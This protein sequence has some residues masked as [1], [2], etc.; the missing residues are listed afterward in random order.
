[1][2]L[3]APLFSMWHK[4]LFYFVC[5]AD[6]L[7]AEL[8]QVMAPLLGRWRKASRGLNASWPGLPSDLHMPPQSWEQ[9]AMPIELS[10]I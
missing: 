10:V 8:E 6:L 9:S 1:M 3:M 5:G 4:L 7:T 2:K